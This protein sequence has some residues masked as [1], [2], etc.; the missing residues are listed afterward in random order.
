MKRQTAEWEKISAN[1][2]TNKVLISK[3][4]KQLI[5]PNIEKANNSVKKM[6]RRPKQTLFQRRQTDS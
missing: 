1:N 3:I 5:Q 6:G 4:Q 2:T